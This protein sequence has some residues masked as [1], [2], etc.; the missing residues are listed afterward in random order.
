MECRRSD[1]PFR[2]TRATKR[3]GLEDPLSASFKEFQRPIIKSSPCI[4]TF[5]SVGW[6]AL[7]KSRCLPLP[8]SP[9]PLFPGPRHRCHGSVSSHFPV[10]RGQYALHKSL[11]PSLTL[12]LSLFL[13]TS[14]SRFRSEWRREDVDGRRMEG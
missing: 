7:G 3:R 13:L 2:G 12:S 11:D 1:E 14:V 4:I 8:V 10:P 9:S 6:K 5:N